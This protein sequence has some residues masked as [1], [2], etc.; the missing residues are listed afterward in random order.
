[1]QEA[2][3]EF[4]RHLAIEKNASAHTVKSYRED[5]TQAIDFFRTHLRSKAPAASQL[6]TRVLRAYLA[7]L[8]EQGYARSTIARRLSA[9]R[10]W[11]RF[12]RRH[13]LLE[14][15]PATGVRGPRL[16]KK[17]PNFIGQQDIQQLLNAPPADDALGTRDR[18]ILETLYSAGL[19]VGELTG[20]NLADLDLREGLATVR[21]KGK[22][23]RLAILGPPA[24]AALT[25]WLALREA[26][27]GPRASGQPALFLSKHGTRLTTR[28]V[29]RLL[30][31]YLAQAGLDPRASPHSLRHSFATHLLDGGADVR[32]VQ[33][34]LGH[35]SLA[36]TQIYTHVTTQRLRDSYHK[37]HPRA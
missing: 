10:T 33:E 22:R 12:L 9:V 31:K 28:S 3:A 14:T 16:E 6:T 27:G 1:M 13:G 2:L 37:A 35:R 36:T 5:L 26:V 4:L 25:A 18:A 34:L 8:H 19:R 15:N 23:E 29:G 32:S 17:L 24:V 7:W 20:L 11:C 30:E 21:G